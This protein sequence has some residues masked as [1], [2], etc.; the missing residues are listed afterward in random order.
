MKF[1]VG[2][3]YNTSIVRITGAQQKTPLAVT[4]SG[5]VATAKLAPNGTYLL[6]INTK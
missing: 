1:K 5:G 4:V 3:A 6:Q 2:D